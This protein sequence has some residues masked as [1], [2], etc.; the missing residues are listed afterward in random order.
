[1]KQFIKAN[2]ASIL[3]SVAISQVITIAGL[4]FYTSTESFDKAIRSAV[5]EAVATKEKAQIEEYRTSRFADF[6]EAPDEVPGNARVYGSLTA[7]FTLAEFSDLECPYCKGLHGTLKEIVD[8]SNGAVNWQ[9]RHMP[10]SFHNPAATTEAHAAECYADQFGNRGFWVMLDEVFQKSGGNGAGVSDLEETVRKLGA[11]TGKYQECMASERYKGHI[12]DQ[13]KLGAKIG[14]TGTPATVLI[15]NLTGEKEF[16]KGN[17]PTKDFIDAMK[18][19][20]SESKVKDAQ[21]KAKENGEPVDPGS[22]ISKQLLGN[23][24]A[25]AEQEKEPSKAAE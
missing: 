17:R 13:A 19:M 6:K 22:V 11:D 15:D 1:M 24:P 18:R 14:A 5:N 12:E 21:A 4:A 7:R 9:F 8:R 20:I 23:P 3:L 25:A 10:L 16:I 2:G